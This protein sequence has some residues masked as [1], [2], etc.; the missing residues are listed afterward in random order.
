M[1]TEE[2]PEPSGCA[3]TYKSVALRV[4]RRAGGGRPRPEEVSAGLRGMEGRGGRGVRPVAAFFR[5]PQLNFPLDF[6]NLHLDIF[7]VSPL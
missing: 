3:Y 2:I 1:V 4:L 6:F 7:N 5:S